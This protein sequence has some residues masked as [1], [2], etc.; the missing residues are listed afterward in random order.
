M[1]CDYHNGFL[2]VEDCDLGA[3]A[4]EV[5]TPC[6]VYSRHALEQ[7]WQDYDGA[8]GTRKHRICYAVKAN[9]NLSVL[10]AL[11]GVGAS[12]DIVSGGELE[13][14][15]A[16]GA[17]PSDL[18]FSG[19]GK[20]EAEI[21]RALECGIGCI[22][23]ESA[24][25]VERVAAIAKRL[26]VQVDVALRVNPDVDAQTHPYI[27]TGLKENK[28]G[29][30]IDAAIAVYQRVADL[31]QLRAT[32]IACH[33][34]SQLTSI[35][36]VVE[37][38][39]QVVRIAEALAVAGMPLEHIDVGGGLGI[40]YEEEQPPPVA[41]LVA[42][43]TR[44]IPER[45][46]VVM[47]PGRSIVGKAG[48]MLTRVEYVKPNENRDFVIVDAAMNDLLRPSLYDA[49]HEVRPY[50]EASG[51]EAVRC[52]LVGPVC[53]TG[54]WLAK[55]RTLA[56]R[57]GDLLAVLDTGAYGFVMS[58]NYNARRRPPEI[59][60]EGASFRV[61]RARETFNELLA[62]ERAHLINK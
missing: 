10:K 39:T 2:Q 62:N 30:P 40:R 51:G 13:R 14:A 56:V 60:V 61:I 18:V 3:I 1:R 48:L 42:G 4:S 36:P 59:L 52:D 28:F 11:Q 9:D 38:V 19:V 17:A 33:I 8:F 53:E 24:A 20:S 6:F 5:G 27:S 7:A 41:E 29:I 35:A 47:E 46:T 25:E 55:D 22:N 16:I 26:A 21:Q 34:G 15:L 32:G 44:A 57:P 31:P 37:A 43:M 45:Y 50:A 54:D 49:W 23:I 58:S 12:F